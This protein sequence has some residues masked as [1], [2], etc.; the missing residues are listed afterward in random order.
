MIASRRTSVCLVDQ[1]KSGYTAHTVGG[2]HCIIRIMPMI[3][4]SPQTWSDTDDSEVSLGLKFGFEEVG[5]RGVRVLEEQKYL[6]KGTV[7]NM[8]LS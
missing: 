4:D 6:S 8:A 2:F 3:T 7:D 1:K 5:S